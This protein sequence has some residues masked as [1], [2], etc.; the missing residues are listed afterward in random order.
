[1][2]ENRV[3]KGGEGVRRVE[4]GV[5]KEQESQGISGMMRAVMREIH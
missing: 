4:K 2:V 5:E 3:E 1:M